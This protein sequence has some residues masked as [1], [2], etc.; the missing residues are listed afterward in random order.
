MR[1]L[2]FSQE[3]EYEY[4]NFINRSLKQVLSNSDWIVIDKS[5]G[6][7]NADKMEDIALIL[8]SKNEVLERRCS[9]CKIKKNKA[10]IIVVFL[11]SGDSYKVVIQNNTFIARHDE[12]GMTLHLS[13]II[14]IQND[15]LTVFYHYTRDFQ[16]YT[17]QFTN[18]M[19][20]IF[21]AESMSVNASTGNFVHDKYDFKKLQLITEEGN[22]SNE[23]SKVDVLKLNVK[24][25]LLSEFKTMYDWKVLENKYL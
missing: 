23:E 22:I 20:S 11:K 18:N 7:L 1:C 16:S 25:K 8:E 6:D 3:K 19:M 5:L 13:P 10:R 14:N 4:P 2:S 15:L 9:S 12:G 24:P 21:S 17:F